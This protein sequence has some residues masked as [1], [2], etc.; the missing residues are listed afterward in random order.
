MSEF[1]MRSTDSAFEIGNRFVL[2]SMSC[3]FISLTARGPPVGIFGEM[4]CAH[5]AAADFP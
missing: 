3:G 4:N 5:A 2:R 1:G